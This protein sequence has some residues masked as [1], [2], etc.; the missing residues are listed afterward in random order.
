VFS[1]FYQVSRGD[2]LPT[3][4][5]GLGLFITRQIVEAH[6]GTISVESMEGEGATFIIRLPLLE[7][8]ADLQK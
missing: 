8:V 1:R 7:D 2:S 4:G 6:D 3:Q 5:L